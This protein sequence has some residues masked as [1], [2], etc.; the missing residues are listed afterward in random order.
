MALEMAPSIERAADVTEIDTMRQIAEQ[1]VF[2]Y[3]TEI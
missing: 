3:L 2:I 1:I